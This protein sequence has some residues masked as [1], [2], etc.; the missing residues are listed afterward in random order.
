MTGTGVKAVEQMMN[1]R[2][3][4]EGEMAY[5]HQIDMNIIPQID[6]FTDNLYTKEEMKMVNETKK[7]MGDE[8]IRLTATAVRIPVVGGHSESIN[9]EFEKEFNLKDIVKILVEAEGVVVID[10][11]ATSSYPMPKDSHDLSLIHISEPTRPY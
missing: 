3:G 8:S 1:E 4:K 11:P 10:D 7:I 6:V 5:P 9:I 2:V